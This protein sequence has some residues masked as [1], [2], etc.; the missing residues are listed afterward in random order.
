M[1][2][3]LGTI[4]LVSSNKVTMVNLSDMAPEPNA[5]A[6][7]SFR[8]INNTVPSDWLAVERWS[9]SKAVQNGQGRCQRPVV[10]I[11]IPRVR[12]ERRDRD[13]ESAWPIT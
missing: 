4:E 7:R 8:H 13:N 12:D 2:S 9:Y 10:N 5:G 6:V 3:C 1:E 11:P